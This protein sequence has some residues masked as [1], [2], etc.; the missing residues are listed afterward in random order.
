MDKLKIVTD[1]QQGYQ[2][3]FQRD[4]RLESQLQQGKTSSELEEYCKLR[5]VEHELLT[6]NILEDG[7]YDIEDF[8]EVGGTFL[9]DTGIS[10]TTYLYRY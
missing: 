5:A 2:K 8:E 9:I 3:A 4:T 7:E 1:H 6:Q 10:V